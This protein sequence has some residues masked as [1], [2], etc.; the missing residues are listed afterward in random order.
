[1]STNPEFA[2]YV[3]VDV[4]QEGLAASPQVQKGDTIAVHYTGRLNDANGKKFDSSLDRGDPLEFGAGQNMVI[5]GWD[6]GLL[7]TKIGEKRNLTIQ[8]EW[9][10]KDKGVGNGLIP[11]NSVLYFECEIVTINGQGASNYQ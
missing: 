4:V 7:G 9:A 11:P 5:K 2:N 3:K 6:E 10:Y 8:P 1:M